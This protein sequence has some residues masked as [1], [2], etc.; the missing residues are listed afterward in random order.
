[1]A[2]PV[3][4]IDVNDDKFKAFQKE[5]EKYQEALKKLPGA[6]GETDKAVEG[7]AGTYATM[8][9]ALLAQQE[10]L[11]T[12]V[13]HHESLHRVARSTDTSMQSLARSTGRVA[14]NI[15]SATTSLL[16][17]SAI[18]TAFSGLIGVGGLW[19]LDR[20]AIASSGAR[21]SA[22]GLGITSGQQQALN[23]TLGRYIDA[24][25]NLQSIVNA[26]NDYS[27]RFRFNQLGIQD[28]AHKDPATLAAEMAIRAHDLYQQGDKSQQFAESHGITQFYTMDEW[29]RLGN[30]SL[31]ELQSVL[32]ENQRLSQQLAVDPRT[33]KAWQ[34]F[35]YR[36][37]TAGQSIE[38]IFITR[39]GP[40]ATPLDHLSASITKAVDNFLSTPKLGE[41]IE[42]LG[43]EI[44]WLGTYLGSDNFQN[45]IRWFGK[46]VGEIA[47]AIELVA[48]KIFNWF[49]V[50]SPT[51]ASPEG[52][53]PVLSTGSSSAGAQSAFE[54]RR[55]FG[56]VFD[57][58]LGW[59]TVP[60]TTQLGGGGFLQGSSIGERP[61]LDRARDWWKT[62]GLAMIGDPYAEDNERRYDLPRGT[63]SGV[64]A[65]ETSSGR[66]LTTSRAG[67]QGY[68]QFMPDT[69]RQYGVNPFDLRSSSEGAGHY[70]SDLYSQ[71]HDRD[72]ALAAYN[73]GPGNLQ[74]DIDQ[75]GENWRM[76]LPE[77]TKRYIDKIDGF[78]AKQTAQASVPRVIV[79]IHNSTGNSVVASASQV[80]V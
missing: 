21:R 2:R 74:R 71:F 65:A 35:D 56:T 1:M 52:L 12:S 29:R 67:A 25:G 37:R 11:A 66:D 14:A 23:L 44:E 18:T 39:L 20:L 63:L 13:D 68:Y 10:L 22:T 9:A 77:E 53:S 54:P 59:T 17:W 36:L 16:K 80:A 38:N 73:W 42:D 3:I 43:H 15:K 30:T 48:K 51:V 69:A 46:E 41:W 28:A 70:L 26:Q 50:T 58:V 8:T 24:N 45:D 55:Q 49:G 72:K 4:D 32:R 62:T 5:F 33:Q 78:L 47:G 19:G 40:L 79:E 7:T 34:D 60:T 57:P 61:F 6:W 75:H 64:F 76:F 27:Q 31:E